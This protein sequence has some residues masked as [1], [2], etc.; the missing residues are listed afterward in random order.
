MATFNPFN[1]D[2]I[3]SQSATFSTVHDDVTG[4]SR[5]DAYNLIYCYLDSGTYYIERGFETFDT[6]SL[7]DSDYIANVTLKLRIEGVSGSDV[8]FN[9]FNS[10]HTDTVADA[11]YDLGG[12]TAYATAIPISNIS[13]GQ[14]ITFTFN[15]AG[16]AAINKTGKTKFCIRQV[17]NDVGN[18]APSSGVVRF[19]YT[20]GAG[21]SN[22]P[23]LTVTI[24]TLTA[25]T[26]TY[27]LTGN[28]V[29]LTRAK[30]LLGTVANY[31]LTFL[32][33]SFTNREGP[34]N[35]AKSSVSTFTNQTKNTSTWS[36]QIKH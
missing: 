13:V 28:S 4:T 14:D 1:D 33:A 12:T 31:L 3:R 9:V 15:A 21:A 5:N 19:W 36:N 7:G 29:N 30:I 23:L 22:K 17:E 2:S 16:R 18:S 11:D 20:N 34:R 6:S 25:D 27:S 35:Q 24:G 10:T 26:G 8:S 32:P